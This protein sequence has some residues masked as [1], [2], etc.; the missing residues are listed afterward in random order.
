MA[1]CVFWACDDDDPV[2]DMPV[3]DETIVFEPING[4]TIMRYT[5]P[6]KTEIAAICARY[7]D[8]FGKDVT[9]LGTPYVD[10]MVLTGFN[11]PRTDVPV[12]ITVTDN[13]NVESAPIERRFNTLASAPY[14]FIDSVEIVSSWNGVRL[15]ASYTG[16]ASGLVDVYRMGINPF[17]KELDTLYVNHFTITTGDM[18]TFM[19][20]PSDS[21]ETTLVL[22]SE[23]GNGNFVRTRIFPNLTQFASAQYPREN[24][25]VSDPGGFSYE[26]DGPVGGA[27]RISNLGIKYLIDG[28]TKGKR[29]MEGQ[30]YA[31]CYYTY[32]TR[33]DG[34][35]SYVQLEL[36]EPQVI[37]SVRLYA[38]LKPGYDLG[39]KQEPWFYDGAYDDRLP[40]HFRIVGSNDP[41]LPLEAWDELAVF[42]QP[43]DGKGDFWPTQ[44]TFKPTE[45]ADYD[46]M[47]P[48]YAEATCEV[49]ETAYKYI[50]VITEDHFD[51]KPILGANYGHY[52][53]YHELEVYVKAE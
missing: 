14:A 39:F 26:Y 17:T 1:V 10:S 31:E 38:A 28:D 29:V 21:T 51:S 53:S 37:A 43:N 13:N 19:E 5:L 6:E 3:P 50:R 7:V 2:F 18:N 9:V 20:V 27:Y 16:I 33:S 15:K 35:G 40:S 48:R 4:G 23:D 22:K 11:A 34:R 42:Y 30:E 49:S 32:V 44:E 45:P 8:D 46:R 36:A 41:E 12:K 47:N 24:L 52:I 25:T